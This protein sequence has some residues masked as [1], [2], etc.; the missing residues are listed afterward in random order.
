MSIALAIDTS[1]R[2]GRIS[3]AAGQTVVFA[4]DFHSERSHNS[5]IFSPLGD[6]IS[7]CGGKLQ[8][9]AVG[10]GPGSYTGVRIGIAAGIGLAM[11]RKVPIAGIPSPCFAAAA[12]L[13]SSYTVVGDARRGSVFVAGVDRGELVSEPSLHPQGEPP[14]IT[15]PVF[16]FDESP[17]LPGALPTIPSASRLAVLAATMPTD[18]FGALARTAPEPIYLRPPFVTQPK[19]P[20]KAVPRPS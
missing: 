10:T 8:R 5:Q 16:T 19:K 14:P 3:V 9:I 2:T 6:A 4:T 13:A 7:A 11:A 15:D 18:D 17:C 1:T 12:P 20:G